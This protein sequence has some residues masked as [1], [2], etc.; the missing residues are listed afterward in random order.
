MAFFFF[1]NKT[2]KMGEVSLS[3]TGYVYMDVSIPVTICHIPFFCF[4]RQRSYPDFSHQDNPAT[5]IPVLKN[6]ILI[7]KESGTLRHA[8]SWIPTATLKILT[9]TKSGGNNESLVLLYRERKFRLSPLIHIS[10][11]AMLT[12]NSAKT[13]KNAPLVSFFNT[14]V[15]RCEHPGFSVCM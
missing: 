5:L 10:Q 8:S 14:T 6:L 7:Q 9:K 12:F 3:H 2:T 15:P 1:S 13:H 11:K 4:C